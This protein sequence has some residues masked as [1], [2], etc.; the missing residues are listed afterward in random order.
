MNKFETFKS[1]ISNHYHG[2]IIINNGVET[3]SKSDARLPTTR[4]HH[5]K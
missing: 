3:N 4:S 2:N 5:S 1:N